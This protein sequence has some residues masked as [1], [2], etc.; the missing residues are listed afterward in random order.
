MHKKHL[1]TCISGEHVDETLVGMRDF[2]A[3]QIA[4]GSVFNLDQIKSKSVR[5]WIEMLNDASNAEA[6]ENQI[7]DE[8]NELENSEFVK[9]LVHALQT[10]VLWSSINASCFNSPNEAS[11]SDVECYFKNV[12]Q[13]VDV[14]LPCRLDEFICAHIQMMEGIHRQVSQGFIQFIDAE[15]GLENILGK[16]SNNYEGEFVSIARPNESSVNESTEFVNE[17]TEFANEDEISQPIKDQSIST[18]AADEQNAVTCIACQNG[19]YP[20]DAHKCIKCNKLVHL[21]DGCSISCGDSEGY[22]E[23]RI[24]ISCSS[25]PTNHEDVQKQLNATEKWSKRKRSTRTS[26]MAPVPNWN[27]DQRVQNRPRISILSNASNTALTHIVDGKR[28]A[29]RNTSSFDSNCQVVFF[30]FLKV[31]N[32]L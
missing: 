3:L 21:F 1:D 12:K 30:S 11:T 18:P 29:L 8:I 17:N 20:T 24:C 2:S 27:L 15:G 25:G 32:I 6:C 23:K 7:S 22:G 28:V 31:L 5:E 26:Y 4:E 16:E 10:L 9:F 14:N 19:N 13:Q